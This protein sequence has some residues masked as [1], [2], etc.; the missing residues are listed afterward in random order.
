STTY[1]T[2]QRPH[3]F[4]TRRS[5][6]LSPWRIRLSDRNM[7]R[8]SCLTIS[9]SIGARNTACCISGACCASTDAE[10]ILEDHEW[11]IREEITA[12]P[13]SEEHTSELQ[14]RFDL[15]CRLLL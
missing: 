10:S 9:R 1:I 15:V 4:A 14:S 6:D 8:I 3:S 11:G 12:L 13:R 5:S 2:H 7:V